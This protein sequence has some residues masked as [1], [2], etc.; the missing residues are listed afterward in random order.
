MDIP[1]GLPQHSVSM[2]ILPVFA[3]I[4][5]SVLISILSPSEKIFLNLYSPDLPNSRSTSNFSVLQSV[6]LIYLNLFN[7][8]SLKLISLGA[9]AVWYPI[10]KGDVPPSLLSV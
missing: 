8:N 1:D 10:L 9:G 7:I 5:L 3:Q 4:S 2:T 6:S